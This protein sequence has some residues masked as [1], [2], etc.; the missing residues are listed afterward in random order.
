M[1]F[2]VRKKE[3]FKIDIDAQILSMIHK[4]WSIL[5]VKN[6]NQRFKFTITACVITN[7]FNRIELYFQWNSNDS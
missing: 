3:Y 4:L 2:I 7:H 6:L 5:C 1:N